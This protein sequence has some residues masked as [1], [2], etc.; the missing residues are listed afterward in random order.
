MNTM[1]T[2]KWRVLIIGALTSVIEEEKEPKFSKNELFYLI[3]ANTQASSTDMMTLI[4]I[5]QT[6]NSW[7]HHSS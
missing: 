2:K 1:I 5:R 7:M 3:T 6:M 4:T